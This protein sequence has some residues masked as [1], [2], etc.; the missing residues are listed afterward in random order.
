MFTALY[1]PI[2]KVAEIVEQVRVVLEQEVMPAE[3]CVLDVG[4]VGWGR[5]R[6]I[7]RGGVGRSGH[8]EHSVRAMKHAHGIAV[9]TH[10]SVHCN[11]HVRVRTQSHVGTH[12]LR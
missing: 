9:H 7:R 3:G 10:S 8:Q 1:S 2:D 6:V 4:G 5:V 11:I 12:T